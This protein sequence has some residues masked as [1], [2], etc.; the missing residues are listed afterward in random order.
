MSITFKQIMSNSRKPAP[1]WFRKFKK[2]FTNTE[3]A[4]LTLLVIKFPADSPIFL[5]IKIGSSWLLETMETVLA[6]GEEYT[7]PVESPELP[8]S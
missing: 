4:V 6:N 5:I 1:R 3:N 8:Q 2:I 7:T